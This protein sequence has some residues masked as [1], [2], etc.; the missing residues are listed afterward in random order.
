MQGPRAF[1]HSIIP[2]SAGWQSAIHQ[3]RYFASPL[4]ARWTGRHAGVLGPEVSFFSV[5]PSLLLV[6]AVKRAE[7]GGG[8]LVVSR[9][10][11]IRLTAA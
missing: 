11:T 10:V 8:D 9:I 1:E 7:D 3:A 4:A 2:H 5:S 6:S